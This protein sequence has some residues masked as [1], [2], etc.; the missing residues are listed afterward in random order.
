MF[1]HRRPLR[2]RAACTLFLWLFGLGASMANACLTAGQTGSV[3]AR[4]SHLVAA[5][6]AHGSLASHDH[7]QADGGALPW[8]GGDGQV[9]QGSLAKTNC[10]DFC[11][12]ATTSVPPLKS[13]LDDVQ[14][15]AVIAMAAMPVLPTTAYA[16]VQ[17]WVPRRDGAQAPPIL[18]TFLRLAL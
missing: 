7:A 17:M 6:E 18:I 2:Q 1:F 16:P 14:S 10:Q 5:V 12:K 4:A 15:H 9:H 11:D 8:P 13:A 3:A